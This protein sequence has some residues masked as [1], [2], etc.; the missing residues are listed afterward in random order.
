MAD[1]QLTANPRLT[2][3]VLAVMLLAACALAWAT[4]VGCQT[5]PAEPAS[6]ARLQ[7]E[8]RQ[9]MKLVMAKIGQY[10]LQLRA[11]VDKGY[12]A[13]AGSQ[14]EAIA[15]L[16]TYLA[17]QRDPGTPANYIRMQAE[18]DEASRE[19]AA[20]SRL[21]SIQD[22]VKSFGEMQA[23]CRSCHQAYRVSLPEPYR[24]VAFTAAKK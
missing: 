20:A 21:K 18:F 9:R 17:P 14:A 7:P 19:L 22:V 4:F 3:R 13:E 10:Y 12:L 23:T 16:E 8:T 24:D 15:T 1:E 11:S 2:R 6:L 5:Q